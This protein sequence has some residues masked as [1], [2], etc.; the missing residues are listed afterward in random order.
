MLGGRPDRTGRQHPAVVTVDPVCLSKANVVWNI[1]H[2]EVEVTIAI[3]IAPGHARGGITLGGRP[4]RM[5]GQHPAIVAVHPVR[6]AVVADGEVE[7]AV[8][9][10]VAPGYAGG[11]ATLGGGPNGARRQHPTVV[12]VQPV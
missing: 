1:P 9:I 8:A 10:H 6:L 5:G 2:G 11:I 7:V 12:A 4:D 3:H